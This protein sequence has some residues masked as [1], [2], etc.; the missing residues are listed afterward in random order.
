MRTQPG[1]KR[2]NVRQETSD[3]KE[4]G[5]VSQTGDIRDRRRETERRCEVVVMR[6]G[7]GDRGQKRGDKRLT[8]DIQ[9]PENE[10]QTGDM[11]HRDR[12]HDT[13]GLRKIGEVRKTD[14]RQT[15]NVR[16]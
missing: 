1:D 14:E 11:K 2:C 10:R 15:G 12:R 5:E 4:T 16:E 13:G 8:G 9:Q 3:R 7:T 6:Q